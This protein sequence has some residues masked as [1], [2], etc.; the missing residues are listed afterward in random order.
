M[1]IKLHLPV[2]LRSQPA[3]CTCPGWSGDPQVERNKTSPSHAHKHPAPR[4]EWLSLADHSANNLTRQGKSW[5]SVSS[6]DSWRLRMHHAWAMESVSFLDAR[7]T[8]L[9]SRSEIQNTES[10][11]QDHGS[12][13]RSHESWSRILDP[14]SRIFLFG[15]YHNLSGS[16]NGR[17]WLIILICQICTLWGPEGC[18]NCE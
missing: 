5:I 11:I 12:W 10:L 9:G 7:S 1:R 13:H 2:R 14:G 16:W 3:Y 15:T 8:S 17:L 6:V 18:K 4:V